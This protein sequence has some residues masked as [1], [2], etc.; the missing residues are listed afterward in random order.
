MQHVDAGHCSTFHCSPIL[1][2]YYESG[3]DVLN[4]WALAASTERNMNIQHVM[5]SV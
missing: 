3:A 1:L 4:N 5:K 2:P